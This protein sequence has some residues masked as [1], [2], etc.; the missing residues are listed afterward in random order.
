MWQGGFFI[1]F[2]KH[3]SAHPNNVGSCPRGPHPPPWTSFSDSFPFPHMAMG[4][5]VWTCLKSTLSS[6]WC[7]T[8]EWR[9]GGMDKWGN[10]M[11]IYSYELDHSPIP[12][13]PHSPIPYVSHCSFYISNS[14]SSVPTWDLLRLVLELLVSLLNGIH[15]FCLH[16]MPRDLLSPKEKG[17]SNSHRI[18]VCHI[19]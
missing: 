4:E 7:L 16:G 3:Q 11:T 8:W 9:N 5:N 14:S 17:C 12:P 2:R 10:G 19:W 18:H 15:R 6:Y 13:F 1:L